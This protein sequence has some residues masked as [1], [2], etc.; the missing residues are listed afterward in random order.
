MHKLAL[1]GL[2][3][4]VTLGAPVDKTGLLDVEQSWGLK[5]QIKEGSQKERRIEALRSRN[6]CGQNSDC[7]HKYPDGSKSYCD[8]K[9]KNKCTDGVRRSLVQIDR[10]LHWWSSHTPTV[11]FDRAS[12]RR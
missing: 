9:G 10:P 7:E 3:Y 8:T 2:Y 6:E 4:T 11:G 5:S 12:P 1:L